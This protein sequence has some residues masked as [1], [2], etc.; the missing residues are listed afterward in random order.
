MRANFLKYVL[1]AR[2]F[3]KFAFLSLY[4]RKSSIFSQ[5]QE[6]PEYPTEGCIRYAL[7]GLSHPVHE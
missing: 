3:M 5:K 4:I 6:N 1:N 2:I 7:Q